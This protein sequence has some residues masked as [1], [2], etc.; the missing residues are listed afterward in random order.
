MTSPNITPRIQF[1]TTSDGVRIA[2]ATL[3]E[4][5]PLVYMPEWVSHIE[6][7]MNG[8]SGPYI[9]RLARNHTVLLYDGRGTGLSDRNASDFSVESRLRDLD[10]VVEH[11]GLEEFVLFSASQASPVGITYAA[12]NLDRVRKLILYSPIAGTGRADH[13]EEKSLIRAVL[14]LIRAEWGV[15]AR[16]TLG[17]VHPDADPREME[18]ELTYLRAASNG[19]VAAAILE[20]NFFHTDVSEELT[21]ITVPTLVLHRRD[22]QAVPLESGRRAA[23]LLSDA[24]F[25]PLE[26]DHHLPFRGDADSVLRAVEEF[27]GVESPSEPAAPPHTH[28]H[29]G[30]PLT[31]LFTDMEGSTALTRRLGDAQAQTLVRRHND[32]VREALRSHGGSE[33]KH[34][35]DGIM[36]S[37]QAASS[38][39]ECAIVVQ[40]A[41]QR[42]HQDD[43]EGQVRVRIGI[44]VGEPVAEDDDLFG[45][46]VQLAR[47]VCDEA[48][49]GQIVVSNVVR[50]LVAGKGFLFSDAGEA[51]LR[52]FDDPVRLYEVR[53]QE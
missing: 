36:A 23:S 51:A 12:R 53:W 43:P 40:R 10:A 31:I 21:K 26:G 44:N 46:A 18:E 16:T 34:T 2:Y 35:G 9:S 25:V 3:G 37:F 41:L 5:P 11:A 15:G 50:E 1:A 13:G 47:R 30:A 52:G 45:T 19:E 28:V 20:Q 39:L 4:G 33:I 14:D 7:E 17:F 49:P 42:H 8:L 48:Q 29:V 22:D 6:I 32:V 38:G 27:L 24:R